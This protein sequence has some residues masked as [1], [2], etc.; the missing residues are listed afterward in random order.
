MEKSIEIKKLTLAEANG[1]VKNTLD[2]LFDKSEA[3]NDI[4]YLGHYKEIVCTYFEMVAAFPTLNIHQVD[5]ND[6]FGKFF[7]GEYDMYVEV[8]KNDR[9]IKYIED[10]LEYTIQI[11]CKYYAG[12]QL[13]NSVTKLINNLNNVVENYADSIDGIGTSDIKGFFKSF[14]EFAIKNNPE[15][16]T[17]AMLKKKKETPKPKKAAQ[18]EDKKADE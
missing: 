11:L 1:V 8:L 2:V 16:I 14:A 4:S 5:I 17:A 9:R 6:F 12:G 3:T 10:T 13:A 15:T 18:T 7:D